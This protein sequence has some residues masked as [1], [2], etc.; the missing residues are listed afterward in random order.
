MKIL[1]NRSLCFICSFLFFAC[2]P[3]ENK[4]E[5]SQNTVYENLNNQLNAD[6]FSPLCIAGAEVAIK[7]PVILDESD[8]KVTLSIYHDSVSVFFEPFRIICE[9]TSKNQAITLKFIAKDGQQKIVNEI[10]SFTKEKS[11][12]DFKTN[13]EGVIL[14]LS[15]INGGFF[16]EVDTKASFKADSLKLLI[17]TDGPFYGGGERFV[18]SCLNGL[19]IPNQPQ[20]RPVASKQLV[21]DSAGVKQYQP[22]YLQVPFVMTPGGEGWYFDNASTMFLKFSDAGESF[23]VSMKKPDLQFYTFHAPTPK[24]VLE[25]YTNLVGRQPEV[26]E[27]GHGVW[28]NLLEGPDSVFRKANYLKDAGMPVSAIWLFDFEDPATSTGFPFWSQSVY[29]DFRRITD[30]LHNL[31]YKVL[32]Y[33]RHFEFDTLFIEGGNNPKYNFYVANGYILHPV[34]DFLPP[35]F[36]NFSIEGQ[37]DFFNPE[38]GTVWENILSTILK[39]YNFDGWMEDF[40][41]ILY[42]LDNETNTWL[43]L[44]FDKDYG[45]THDQYA[46]IYN[47][48]YHQLTYKL[49]TS[50]KEDIVAFSRSGSAGS[51]KYSPMIWAGDQHSN[52]N[53]IM[54]YPTAVTAGISCGLSGYSNWTTDI[55]CDSP[56]K[57]LWKRWVQFGTF[58]SLMRDH[59]WTNKPT[60]VDIWTDP[61]SFEYFKKYAQIHMDLVPYIREMS[62]KY[63]ETGTPLIRHMMLEFPDDN[64][65][66]FCEY[67]YMFGNKYLVAPVVEDRATSKKVYFP[68]GT[69]KNFWDNQITTSVGEW[70]E[71]KAPV[72]IIPVFERL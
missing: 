38:M 65:T 55:L 10:K 25:K 60:A 27:W 58:T 21:Q 52:W 41:D 1:V 44:D 42:S 51:A 35:R 59:L 16:W 39:Q 56:S 9:G 69:W 66:W 26:P 18:G 64:K 29:P 30:S 61:E 14:K 15:G 40:G 70:I 3:G 36:S 5:F 57:E 32:S 63:R 72:D 31:G 4:N 34:T 67:Q 11:T 7:P 8:D 37:Y 24:K 46:N 50:I 43:P 17:E 22:S 54:G 33:L 20:N 48:V 45:I 6:Y 71:V 62:K 12:I 68:K 23:T 47:L 13:I 49:S 53:K 2:K 28:I 19:A